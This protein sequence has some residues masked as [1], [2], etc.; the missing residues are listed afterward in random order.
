MEQSSTSTEELLQEGTGVDAERLD[1][2]DL[3]ST[4]DSSG[5]DFAIELARV[6]SEVKVKEAVG[7]LHICRCNEDCWDKIACT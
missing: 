7:F 6:A 3:A 5:E 4:S 1:G 2:T